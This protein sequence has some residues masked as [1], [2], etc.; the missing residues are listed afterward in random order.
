MVDEGRIIQ[1]R[2]APHSPNGFDDAD[3]EEVFPPFN[4][5]PANGPAIDLND[6][7]DLG[8]DGP[9]GVVD[10][11]DTES[12]Y[13]ELRDLRALFDGLGVHPTPEET[14]G[15]DDHTNRPET[16]SFMKV[17]RSEYYDGAA[18]IYEGGESFSQRFSQ[19]RYAEYR[20]ATDN[21]YFP[22]AS[23]DEWEFTNVLLNLKCSQES[24]NKLLQ[25]KLV[26]I[27]LDFSSV[28]DQWTLLP[29]KEIGIDV[30]DN[31]GG[32]FAHRH[33]AI[34]SSMESADNQVR[35]ISH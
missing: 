30:P 2:A 32:K 11:S 20:E 9:G 10:G 1:I 25:T 14:P 26:C 23:E 17:H 34:W 35:G 16:A 13:D 19:D 18:R 24:K 7:F 29:A 15:D 8:A 33:A 6:S 22:M 5:P 31:P 3:P 4:G 12:I 21:I 28:T 27:S